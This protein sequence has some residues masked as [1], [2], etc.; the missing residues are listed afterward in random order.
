MSIG[1]NPRSH[2]GRERRRDIGSAILLLVNQKILIFL[3]HVSA[4][5]ATTATIAFGASLLS[6]RTRPMT[7]TVLPLPRARPAVAVDARKL[8]FSLSSF[9]A[10]AATLGIAFVASLPRPWWAILT[11]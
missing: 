7:A 2:S 3:T 8:L 10:G 11:V 5:K 6:A 4:D 1:S 9:V